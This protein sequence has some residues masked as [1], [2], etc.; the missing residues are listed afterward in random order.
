MCNFV[1]IQVRSTYIRLASYFQKNLPFDNP[2][3]KSV[4]FLNLSAVVKVDESF[5]VHLAKRLPRVVPES[6]INNH[7]SEVRLLNL[8]PGRP[9]SSSEV[10]TAAAWHQIRQLETENGEQK[11]PYLARLTLAASTLFHGNADIERVFDKMHDIDQDEK[12]NRIAGNLQT[13]G[14]DHCFFSTS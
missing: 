5:V 12:Q 11:F 3:L 13:I 2:Y 7:Q 10:S 14:E 4:Q 8:L 1:C 9:T 6:H